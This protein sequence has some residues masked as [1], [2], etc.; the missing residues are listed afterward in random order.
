MRIIDWHGEKS[1][2]PSFYIDPD[3]PPLWGLTYRFVRQLLRH[4]GINL[5]MAH[6]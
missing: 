5:Q 2:V 3:A 1:A 4:C 6:N